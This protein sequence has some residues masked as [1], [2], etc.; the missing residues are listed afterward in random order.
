MLGAV[1]CIIGPLDLEGSPHRPV[2]F[3]L[4]LEYLSAEPLRLAGEVLS[5]LPLTLFIP[6]LLLLALTLFRAVLRRDWAAFAALGGLCILYEVIGTADAWSARGFS[7]L[8]LALAFSIT[9][10]GLLAGI[11]SYSAFWILLQA[12]LTL[13]FSRWYAPYS[14][15]SLF[16]FVLLV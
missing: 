14:A 3:P 13:D 6:V 4:G 10:F 5:W 9:R 1:W 16:L 2:H 7:V 15:A 12:P 8:M 11:F